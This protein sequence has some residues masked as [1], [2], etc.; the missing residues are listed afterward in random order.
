MIQVRKEMKKVTASPEEAIMIEFSDSV[1]DGQDPYS[2]GTKSLF[3]I[4]RYQA[5]KSSF[6][7]LDSRKQLDLVSSIIENGL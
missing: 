2:V 6:K 3:D 4:Q 7:S 5:F 1:I